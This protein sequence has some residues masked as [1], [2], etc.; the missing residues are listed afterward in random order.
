MRPLPFF[1]STLQLAEPVNMTRYEV[2]SHS[3]TDP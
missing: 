1:A 2:T 3:I